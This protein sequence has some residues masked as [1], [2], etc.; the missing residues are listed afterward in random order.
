VHLLT[1]PFTFDALAIRVRDVLDLT[2][3]RPD[4]S[5]SSAP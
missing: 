4:K 1:K 5:R 2:G 3:P